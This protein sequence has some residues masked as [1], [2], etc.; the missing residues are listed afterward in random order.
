MLKGFACLCYGSVVCIGLAFL[1][2]AAWCP[3][4]ADQKIMLA[5]G[6]ASY[7]SRPWIFALGL[8]LISITAGLA[9]LYETLRKPDHTNTSPGQ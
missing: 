5:S 3:A 1:V 6:S 2:A 4:Y 7:T 8:G 9:G